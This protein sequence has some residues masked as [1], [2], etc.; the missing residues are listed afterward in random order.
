MQPVVKGP[1]H[2]VIISGILIVGIA[3]F[4]KF[5]ILQARARGKIIERGSRWVQHPYLTVAVGLP[6]VVSLYLSINEVGSIDIG[7]MGNAVCSFIGISLY[8]ISIILW[9]WSAIT[10]RYNFSFQVEVRERQE[11][12]C[13]GPYRYIRHP[14]YSSFLMMNAGIALSLRNIIHLLLTLF[15]IFPALHLRAREEEVLLSR[16]FGE[17]YR[18]YMTNI[19]RFIPRIISFRKGG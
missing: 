15:I 1:A 3:G 12:I 17:R 14:M 5:L 6:W 11:F 10:L 9:I 18:D 16:Y 7:M 2:V 19:P 4:V 13:A 8:V